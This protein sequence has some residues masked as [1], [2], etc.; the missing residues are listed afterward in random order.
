[1]K[2]NFAILL[3]LFFLTAT[4]FAQENFLQ[5]VLVEMPDKTHV[6]FEPGVISSDANL[7]T[8]NLQNL[9]QTATAA[10]EPNRVTRFLSDQTN[11]VVFGYTVL[12]EPLAQKKFKISL[13]PLT[14]NIQPPSRILPKSQSLSGA[15]R[16]TKVLTLPNVTWSQIIAEGDALTVDLL[17]HA[18]L[19]IK[20]TDK[21]RV[22]HNRERLLPQPAFPKDFTLNDLQIAVTNLCVQVNADEIKV[23]KSYS[24]SLVWLHLPGKGFFLISLAPR[25]GYDFRKIG[26]IANREIEFDFKGDRYKLISDTD[27]LPENGTW[28]AWVL[29]DPNHQPFFVEPA[30][31]N[32]KQQ[33]KP[34]DLK[35]PFER[36]GSIARRTEKTGLE[37]ATPQSK[38]ESP[39]AKPS[40]AKMRT[41]AVSDIQIIYPKN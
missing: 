7:L 36:N 12:I 10:I 30:P 20:I 11:G 34:F 21:I 5:T 8:S 9:R 2:N 14:K 13:E 28:F 26:T 39:A 33:E 23:G 24:G 27:I 6:S 16:A 37:T 35:N 15:R 1:M 19:N 18:G 25:S 32:S 38:T 3:L 17:E 41:G 4:A 40:A 31:D 29:H 22:A